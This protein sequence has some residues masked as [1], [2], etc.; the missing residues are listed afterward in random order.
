MAASVADSCQRWAAACPCAVTSCSFTGAPPQSPARAAL[1]EAEMAPARRRAIEVRWGIIHP[2]TPT[3][4]PGSRATRRSRRPP[5]QRPASTW[6]TEGGLAAGRT[7]R[8]RLS[9]RRRGSTG[10]PPEEAVCRLGRVVFATN[11]TPPRGNVL[12]DRLRAVQEPQAVIATTEP[13]SRPRTIGVDSL[14][15]RAHRVPARWPRGRHTIHAQA[16][17]DDWRALR[18]PGGVVASA[19]GALCAA[20]MRQ[21][22]LPRKQERDG[23]TS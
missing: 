14:R 8:R 13:A 15:R 11:G 16:V 21:L 19:A 10:L 17:T 6:S 23:P 18:E 12:G 3:G 9:T 4:P 2:E 1:D 7:R 5:F 22:Q 20:V